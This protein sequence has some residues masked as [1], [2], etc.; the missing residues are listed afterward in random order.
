MSLKKEEESNQAIWA[1]AGI[2]FFI[3]IAIDNWVTPY[4]EQIKQDFISA[5][6]SMQFLVTQWKFWLS[7]F[8]IITLFLILI[9]FKIINWIAQRKFNKLLA[10]EKRELEE[11]LRKNEMEEIEK[12]GSTPTYGLNSK[13]L[14]EIRT[15]LERKLKDSWDLDVRD[16]IFSYM[17]KLSNE[18][19]TTERNEKLEYFENRLAES[20]LKLEENE[21]KNREYEETSL[22]KLN[23]SNTPVFLE[24]DLTEKD[25]T[26]LLKHG[27]KRA[28]EFCVFEQE[29]VH[30]FVKPTMKHSVTHTF[31]VWS[32]VK[33]ISKINGTSNVYDWDTREA[34]VSFKYH[35]KY[36][37]VEIETGTLLSK[38][39]QLRRK[40]DYLNSRYKNRWMIIVSKKSLLSKYRK[41]GFTSCRSEF[42]DK[43]K[44][45]LKSA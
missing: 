4:F 17:R 5:Q 42:P 18:I 12:I 31:L 3:S 11:K 33:M 8:V 37:A 27:Y 9:S 16:Q 26:L 25:K 20:K 29:N 10:E 7:I 45:L 21:R 14:R 34:D 23:A 32:A 40:I 22:K 35:D 36:F 28:Y 44:K 30:V 39:V 43:M 24:E 1:V 19:E 15:Q 13:E 38:R 6:I 2:L 41:F